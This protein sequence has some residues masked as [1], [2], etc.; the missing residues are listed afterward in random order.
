M[1]IG[2]VIKMFR[3]YTH[4]EL[5]DEVRS[6][7]GYYCPQKEVRMKYDGREVLYVMGQANVDASCCANGCW[8]YALVPG[9]IV[10]W[11]K[12]KTDSGLWVSEVEPISDGETKAEVRQ[13]IKEAEAVSQVDFW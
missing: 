6:I 10:E 3:T 2:A 9:F 1:K 11:Q 4:L 13:K 5:D 12:E 7:S 8:E